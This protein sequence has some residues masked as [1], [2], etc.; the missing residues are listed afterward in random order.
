MKQALIA[1]SRL[2]KAI[3]LLSESFEWLES[4]G[5]SKQ[6]QTVFSFFKLFVQKHH[7]DPHILQAVP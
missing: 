4:C 3:F 5:L 6:T 7:M 2:D 1:T